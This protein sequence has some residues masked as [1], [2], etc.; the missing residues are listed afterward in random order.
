MPTPSLGDQ[1]DTLELINKEVAERLARLAASG[2]Q[3]DT[4]AALV[5]GVA[6]TAT[7]FLAT[8]ANAHELLATISYCAF[9][10]AFTSAVAAYA[11][12]R[13]YDVPDPRDLATNFAHRSKPETLAT[14]I[15]TRVSAFETNHRRHRRK[16]FLWWVSVG[17]L[18]A[19][20]AL[21]TAAIMQTGSHD[22]ACPGQPSTACPG[23]RP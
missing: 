14:L 22:R 9:A 4:K 15:A 18:A 5:G 11:V 19:G 21:S 17:L 13:H 12:V 10:L 16:V 3:L 8:R 6:A 20:L 1:V 23:A 2:S 7:Q